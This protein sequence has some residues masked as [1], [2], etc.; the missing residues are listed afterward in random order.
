MRTMKECFVGEGELEVTQSQSLGDLTETSATDMLLDET[1]EGETKRNVQRSN[2]LQTTSNGDGVSASSARK[3]RIITSLQNQ[4]LSYS[5]HSLNTQNGI[6]KV[7]KPQNSKVESLNV[8]GE[9]DEEGDTIE[10]IRVPVHGTRKSFRKNRLSSTFL[11]H[12]PKKEPLVLSIIVTYFSNNGDDCDVSADIEFKEILGSSG[13]MAMAAE[14]LKTPPLYRAFFLS[15]QEIDLTVPKWYAPIANGD[16]IVL[17]CGCDFIHDQT[18]DVVECWME[19][20]RNHDI[21]DLLKPHCGSGEVARDPAIKQMSKG[22]GVFQKYVSMPLMTSIGPPKVHETHHF[23]EKMFGENEDEPLSLDRDDEEEEVEISLNYV[24]EHHYIIHPHSHFRFNWDL[25]VMVAITILMFSLPLQ[26]AFEAAEDIMDSSFFPVNMV[27]D[28]FFLMD[29]VINFRTGYIDHEHS[30][31]VFNERAI[32][33]EYLRTWFLIDV[34]SLLPIDYCLT[35]LLIG[36][37]SSLRASKII[38]KLLRWPKMIKILRVSRAVRYLTRWRERYGINVTV[39]RIV[40]LAILLFF[41]VHWDACIMFV[42]QDTMDFPRDGW[43][44]QLGIR[45]KTATEK[46]MWS[47]FKAISH[48]LCIGY[49]SI[50]P[51]NIVDAT[52]ITV[53]MVVGA[54]LY[55]CMIGNIAAILMNDDVCGRAFRE[56]MDNVN[57]YLKTKQVPNDLRSRVHDYYAHR[58]TQHKLFN[59]MDILAD[60]SEP[61]AIEICLHNCRDL[62]QKVPFFFDAHPEF[63]R[64]V[65]RKLRPM[66]FLKGDRIIRQGSKGDKMYFIRKGRVEI[67]SVETGSVATTISSGSYFGEIALLSKAPGT[68]RNATVRATNAVELYSLSHEDLHSILYEYPELMSAMEKIATLRLHKLQ[69]HM[70]KEQRSHVTQRSKCEKT[71]AIRD[72]LITEALIEEEENDRDSGARSFL[73]NRL[74]GKSNSHRRVHPEGSGTS[75]N[76]TTITSSTHLSGDYVSVSP[77]LNIQ[78]QSSDALDTAQAGSSSRQ[79]SIKEPAT[80]GIGHRGRNTAPKKRSP[81]TK[82][83]TDAN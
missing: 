69:T 41:F 68:T 78:R 18:H 29:I 43:V 1:E 32:A 56:K 58:Y 37:Y 74:G 38:I 12:V 73:G 83:N 82:E 35:A 80:L 5:I 7:T 79:G 16:V 81:L 45:Y 20:E 62:V 25:C 30:T 70:E 66:V 11:S 31:V 33:K 64:A 28:V 65:V 3:Q 57:E 27:L 50:K 60:L 52:V 8:G 36:N 54:S 72:D 21:A 59:E 14:S 61:L 40:K 2:S 42:I 44:E 48:M 53:S 67:F 75:L 15:G 51:T 6:L 71:L 10:E 4:G 13:F 55:A 76:S 63:I 22:H 23:K 46:Y 49:G 9:E 34:I 39:L 19:A 17:T 77:D 26:V 24:R 47:L